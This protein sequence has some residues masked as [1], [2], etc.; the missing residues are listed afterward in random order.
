[1]RGKLKRHPLTV[2]YTYDNEVDAAYI[3]FPIPG[4][5]RSAKTVEV[6]PNVYVDFDK[7]GRILGLE[8]ID[9]RNLPLV[10]AADIDAE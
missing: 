8:I 10:I 1:M 9:G 3:A 4:K 6:T 5:R 2:E 7:R